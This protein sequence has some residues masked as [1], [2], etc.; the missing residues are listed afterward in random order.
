[1]VHADLDEVGTDNSQKASLLIY[2]LREIA[3]R[4]METTQLWPRRDC[5]DPSQHP[6]SRNGRYQAKLGIIRG[7]TPDPMLRR[8]SIGV[9]ASTVAIAPLPLKAQDGSAEALGM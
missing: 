6:F 7:L 9:P 8:L 1:M 3:A 5:L 4:V 2:Q